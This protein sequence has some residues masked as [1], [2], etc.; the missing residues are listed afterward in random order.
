LFFRCDLREV[1]VWDPVTEAVLGLRLSAMSF[2]FS[3]SR[4]EPNVLNVGIHR[5]ELPVTKGFG[6]I[7][8]VFVFLIK[9]GDFE[10]VVVTRRFEVLS[11]ETV[12]G[13]VR[14]PPQRQ[15]GP[16][17][18]RP[19]PAPA[20]GNEARI[21]ALLSGGVVVGAAS[22]SAAAAAVAVAPLVHDDFLAP[23]ASVS[24]TAASAAASVPAAAAVRRRH[25]VPASASA[26]SAS[27]PSVPAPLDQLHGESGVDAAP[28]QPPLKRLRVSFDDEEKRALGMPVDD[29]ELDF[30]LSPYFDDVD[31]AGADDLF[32]GAV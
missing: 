10:E 26:S 29:P 13:P 3:V 21:N 16:P 23:V 9:D 31:F 1:E 6:D 5:K 27:V 30:E 18:R 20:H 8:F 25:A 28:P 7:P 15:R 17:P 2:A 22:A 32:A 12:S 11:K 4:T 24:V 14:G 19:F